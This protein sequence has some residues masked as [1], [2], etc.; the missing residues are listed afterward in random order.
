M[1]ILIT[2]AAGFIGSHLAEALSSSGHEVLGLDAF[3]AYYDRAAKEQNAACVLRSGARLVEADL[4]QDDLSPYL[5]GVQVVFHLAAQPGLSPTTSEADYHRNNVLATERLLAASVGQPSLEMF[6]YIS[7][8]SVYGALATNTEEAEPKPTST[9]GR[10]K[11]EAEGLVLDAGQG[12]GLPVC[13]LRIFSVYGPRERPEKLFPLLIRRI[14]AGRPVPLFDGSREH[15]RSFTY[16]GDIVSG[17]LAALERRDALA[18]EVINLGSEES[19]TTGEAIEL[20]EE[21][22]GCQARFETLPPR[23]GDQLK[24]AARIDKAK[25]LLGYAPSTP[26]RRGLEAEVA[27]FV[28]SGQP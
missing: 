19:F 28:D 3:T 12:G 24:T 15:E 17:F 23:E 6:F 22:M 8:S 25:R 9:Y 20:V 1:K 7:T 2:G 21:I 14:A 5:E 26:L 10:T 18:G 16:V 27:W 13:S 11:L 4:A